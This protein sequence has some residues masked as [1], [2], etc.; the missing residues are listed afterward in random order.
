MNNSQII[1][2]EEN[3][4]KVFMDSGLPVSIIDLMLFRIYT[5]IN[6]ELNNTLMKERQQAEQ[7]VENEQ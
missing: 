5:K 2:V 3:V 7:Q 1:E 4:M 6:N